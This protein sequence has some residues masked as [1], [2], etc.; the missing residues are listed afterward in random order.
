MSVASPAATQKRTKTPVARGTFAFSS[1]YDVCWLAHYYG[2]HFTNLFG[3]KV[4][5]EQD[6]L[7]KL[8]A[9]KRL[10]ELMI[11]GNLVVERAAMVSICREL[12]INVVHTEDGF[13]PH[14][15][16]MHADPLGFCWE[17]SLPRLVFRECLGIQRVRARGAR[18]RWLAFHPKAL[19]GNVRAPFV[20][21]PL[22]LI[23]DQVNLWDLKVK[24]WTRLIAHFRACL[25]EQYQL[26]IKEHPRSKE[27]DNTGVR[28]LVQRL[29]NTVLVPREADLKSLLSGCCAV[30]GANSTVLYEARLMFH[31]PAY[32]Y[33][34]GWFTNHS[35]LF[36]P[37]PR[38]EPRPLN[39]LDWLEENRRLRTE[40]L[41]D[42]T[43]WFLSHLLAR[44]IPLELAELDP[45]R[46]KRAVH[47]LSYESFVKYG[48]EVFLDALEDWPE[49]A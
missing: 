47:R 20:F 41:D 36:I 32:S 14:Y 27:N 2:L 24:D 49:T 21:W 38:R 12:A 42:Y 33:A 43:D 8:K 7:L 37:V 48:E 26:V 16:T 30:A 45:K 31:K 11:M 46:L 22:Q 1:P 6:F 9:S 3:A 18:E 28:E 39:R 5:R 29:P 25:G 13:F 19:P 40:R 34:R 23:G 10:P 4:I 17:S 44:Q 35:E 15:S